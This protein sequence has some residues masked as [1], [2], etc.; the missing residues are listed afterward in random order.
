MV[1]LYGNILFGLTDMYTKQVTPITNEIKELYHDKIKI[2][3]Y[4]GTINNCYTETGYKMTNTGLFKIKQFTKYYDYGLFGD[5]HSFQY[6]DK[7]N[8]F[9]YSSSLVEQRI[10]EANQNHGFIC[11]TMPSDSK[12]LDNPNNDSEYIVIEND[13]KY[14]I[15]KLIDNILYIDNGKKLELY[16]KEK[17]NVLYPK[18]RLYYKNTKL[19]TVV[20]VE[21]MIKKNHEISELIKMNDI[22]EQ[23]NFNYGLEDDNDDGSNNNKIIEIKDYKTIKVLIN[24]FIKKYNYNW[25]I[26]KKERIFNTL[27][28][29][30]KDIDLKSFDK[31]IIKLKSLEFSNLFSYGENNKL[32]FT[33]FG[34]N[35]IV[36]ILGNNSYGKSS[37]IDAILYSIY[38]IFSRG[39]NNDALNINEKH[40]SSSVNLNINNNDFVINRSI[41]KTG[42]RTNSLLELEM[43]GQMIT[44]DRKSTTTQNI[45][46]YMCNY[47]DIVNSH[48]ILQFGENFLDISDSKKRDYLYQILNL[49]L[50]NDIVKSANSKKGIIKAQEYAYKNSLD[51]YD[52]ENINNEITKLKS[53]LNNIN[54]EIKNINCKIDKYNN[55]ILKLKIVVGIDDDSIDID[56]NE[57]N[58]KIINHKNNIDKLME[59]KNELVTQKQENNINRT[60]YMNVLKNNKYG[61]T[62]HLEF[63][64]NKKIKLYE[65]NKIRDKLLEKIV[66]ID[67]NIIHLNNNLINRLENI[68]NNKNKISN[69]IDNLNDLIS[70]YNQLIYPV[71]EIDRLF[72]EYNKNKII[73]ET[74]SN[75]KI[76]IKNY[77]YKMKQLE[78]HKYDPK[79]SFCMESP[80]VKEKMYFLQ[81]I[82]DYKNKLMDLKFDSKLSDDIIIK[83]NDN[84]RYIKKNNK[85]E[86]NKI[87]LEKDLEIENNNYENIKYK[88]DENNKKLNQLKNNEKYERELEFVNKLIN[89]YIEINDDAYD[90]YIKITNGVIDCDSNITSINNKLE[91]NESKL[92]LLLLEYNQYT[93]IIDKII[94]NKDVIKEIKLLEEKIRYYKA[95]YELLKNNSINIEKQITSY[96]CDIKKINELKNN[97]YNCQDKYESYSEINNIIETKNGLVNHIMN[98]II[99]GQIESKV[100]NILN[101]V[102]DFMIELKY[103][104]KR[105]I[106]YKK[107]GNKILKAVNLCGFERFVC[108]MAFRLVFNNIN[109]KIS[110]DFLIIDEGFSCCDNENL[111]KIKYL[112]DFIKQKYTWCLAITHLETIKDYFDKVI[113]IDKKND[114]SYIIY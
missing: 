40:C 34:K 15:L 39:S 94:L 2:A 98:N 107:V 93:K 18:I 23:L 92:N 10:S 68:S 1:Y 42:T 11:W 82:N 95:E 84:D 43:N 29:I 88:I 17:I 78:Y 73:G 25:T 106:V 75:I 47:E 37:L 14:I 74:I 48:I 101:L 30:I 5:I 69:D 51:K 4:H 108:N 67:K 31:K 99:L 72:D 45:H 59:Q 66:H 28:E 103:D 22:D 80:I 87:L 86:M 36:G 44:N 109:A 63:M 96:E 19:S 53:D 97:I 113:C 83:K 114:K 33:K 49:D 3:L 76:E 56:N 62:E 70:E 104:N 57:I 102:T 105:I 12:N 13:Y 46:D 58:N 50:F 71:D 35:K 64:E 41:N 112:F 65:L 52:Y 26:E 21:E 77:E 91:L 24:G 16:S 20:K 32:D 6:L 54:E 85:C 111:I 100:N 27:K 89:H 90:E 60:N 79:C 9:A 38:D 8:R 110:C 81:I 61:Y 7:L 55:K